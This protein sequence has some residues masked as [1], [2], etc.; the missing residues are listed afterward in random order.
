[1]INLYQYLTEGIFDVDDNIEDFDKNVFAKEWI[2]AQSMSDNVY[3]RSTKWK[4]LAD[5][6]VQPVEG[7]GGWYISGNIPKE[8]TIVDAS[9]GTSPNIMD[10]TIECLDSIQCSQLHI[11]NTKILDYGKGFKGESIKINNCDIKDFKWFSKKLQWL[12]L[13]SLKMENYDFDGIYFPYSMP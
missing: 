8:I 13:T 2:K 1:M 7:R 9:N 6:S 3:V 5:G 12:T 4:I 10:A 11:T